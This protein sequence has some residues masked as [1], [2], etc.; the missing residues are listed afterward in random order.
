MRSNICDSTGWDWAAL[1]AASAREAR[2]IVRSAH[3]ADEIAQEALLRAWRRSD[4]CRAPE[5]PLPWVLK[6]TRMETYRHLERGATRSRREGAVLA[7]QQLSPE[8]SDSD[9]LL[10]RISVADALALL[11][12]DEQALV[13][14]RYVDDLT[15]PAAAE[16]LGMP[17]GTAKVRLHRIRVRLRAVLEE[18]V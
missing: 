16:L 14:A 3:D 13:T 18:S 4:S 9:A 7:E 1:R 8:P 15:Q 17:E 2:R 6:I 11:T 12:S 10:R 5:N